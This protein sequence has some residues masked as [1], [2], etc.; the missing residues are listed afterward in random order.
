MCPH[1]GSFHHGYEAMVKTLN[2]LIE[3]NQ[4]IKDPKKKFLF[5]VNPDEDYKF[6]LDKFITVS[7]EDRKNSS[8]AKFQSK[9]RR[10]FV[11]NYDNNSGD[12]RK[13]FKRINKN[14][15]VLFIAY[16]NFYLNYPNLSNNL[17]DIAEKRGAKTVL[18]CFSIEPDAVDQEM[19]RDLKKFDF[20]F[21][22]ERMTFDLLTQYGL[23]NIK[24]CP[25]TSFLLKA[26]SFTS[27]IN[28]SEKE[29]I[30]I[31]LSTTILS[32][33]KKHGVV[34]KNYVSLINHLIE[35][36][37]YQIALIPFVM[38]EFNDDRNLLEKLYNQFKNS[39][40]VFLVAKKNELNANQLKY[41]ISKCKVMVTSRFHVAIASFSQ[42]IPTLVV[43]YSVRTLGI[44]NDLFGSTEKYILPVQ[45]LV[46]DYD[47]L[48]K[49]KIVD[50]ESEFINAH[51]NKVLPNYINQID[52]V[53][54]GVSN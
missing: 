17:N 43:G 41:I 38:K 48:S 23:K 36:T 46:N 18:C 47:L 6:N 45:Q 27:S 28:F 10:A 52:L 44:A 14:S 20:I 19:L 35:N 22:R 26:K 11:K 25:D 5:S 30:G 34:L 3:K 51:L 9:L 12:S 49:F 4:G 7:K 50:A 15:I 29:I 37:D 13:L 32:Y 1:I 54:K 40:R 24:F 8:L 53:F 16:E 33:E 42:S 2:Y 39:G 21:A 31:N